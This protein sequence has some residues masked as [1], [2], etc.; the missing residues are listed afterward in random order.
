[1]YAKLLLLLGPLAAATAGKCVCPGGL[2]AAAA[3]AVAGHPQATSYC[4]SK[5]P[6]LPKTS[7]VITTTTTTKAVSTRTETTKGVTVTAP[8][9]ASATT[10]T[11]TTTVTVTTV[12]STDNVDTTFVTAT[13][14]VTTTA[15]QT[16]TETVTVT[17]V[18]TTVDYTGPV[19]VTKRTTYP[20]HNPKAEAAFS[21]LI[22]K[23]SSFVKT[24]CACIQ[25][26]SIVKTTSTV[27]RTASVTATV[28]AT[29]AATVSVT[30]TPAA[31]TTAT[32]TSTITTTTTISSVAT[33]TTTADPRTLTTTVTTSTQATVIATVTETC[34]P[35][36]P[37]Y[38]AANGGCRAPGALDDRKNCGRCGVSCTGDDSCIAGVCRQPNRCA[39]DDFCSADQTTCYCYRT[40]SGNGVCYQNGGMCGARNC[41][42]SQDCPNGETCIAEG[43]NCCT[44][45]AGTALCPAPAS[46]ARLFRRG[47]NALGVLRVPYHAPGSA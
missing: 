24:A 3:Q 46:A 27:T 7:T 45:A 4:V 21:S 37:N 19:I 15:T 28:T 34:A 32:A 42:T 5:Y 25:A 8:V 20:T 35:S 33:S 2:Y 47:D 14:T 11:A 36:T 29:V 26:P 30:T 39:P 1:M 44:T 17:A 43:T 40:R 6:V 41:Q 22:K 18:T 10:T 13:P 23:A 38:C 9:T 31:T 16:N 12:A